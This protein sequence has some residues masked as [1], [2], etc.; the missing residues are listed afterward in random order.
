[1]L[2]KVSWPRLGIPVSQL[3]DVESIEGSLQSAQLEL[4][5]FPLAEK[6]RHGSWS[7]FSA[8]DSFMNSS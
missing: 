7:I 4:T 3:V 6:V 1:M 8:T 5:E 2:Q